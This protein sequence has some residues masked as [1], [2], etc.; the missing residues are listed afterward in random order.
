MVSYHFDASY[1][2]VPKRSW[3]SAGGDRQS[4]GGYSRR[5]KS[6]RR[7]VRGQT[8]NLATDFAPRIRYWWEGNGL[9]VPDA[10]LFMEL[11][12]DAQAAG[13]RPPES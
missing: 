7:A 13:R 5:S 8:F 2:T 4:A 10:N 9:K 6:Y 11:G 3:Y 12:Q 1:R